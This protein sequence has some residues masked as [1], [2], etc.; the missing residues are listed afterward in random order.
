MDVDD[1]HVVV[2]RQPTR[3]LQREHVGRAGAR[4]RVRHA[5]GKNLDTR[6]FTEP[7]IRAAGETGRAIGIERDGL[8]S[9]TG[10]CAVE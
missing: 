3:I 2:R 4:Q 8:R 9:S 10:E 7:K 5:I 6:A 1:L